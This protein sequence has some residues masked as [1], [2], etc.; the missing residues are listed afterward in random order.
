MASNTI[1]VG[2][3]TDAISISRWIGSGIYC[4]ADDIAACTIMRNFAQ[5]GLLR[6]NVMR[7]SRSVFLVL[8]SD[9]RVGHNG[10]RLWLLGFGVAILYF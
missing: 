1:E 8:T 6:I 9:F 3:I 2:E 7:R 5:A 4:S 10:L